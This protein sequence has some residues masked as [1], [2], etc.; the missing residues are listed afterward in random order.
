MSTQSNVC[1]NILDTQ[2][3]V[4]DQ[5]KSVLVENLLSSGKVDEQT[6]SQI[7]TQVE[8]CIDT[9]TDALIDRIIDELTK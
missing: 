5:V 6:C 9:Q 2:S 4:K 7:S 3:V 1:R 8:R